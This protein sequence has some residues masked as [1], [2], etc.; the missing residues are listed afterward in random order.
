MSDGITFVRLTCHVSGWHL[1]SIHLA[2]RISCNQMAL[3]GLS[4]F[5]CATITVLTFGD[6]E[7]V[8]I[9][10]PGMYANQ[11]EKYTIV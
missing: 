3:S 7:D 2:P 4:T 11:N 1:R 10:I 8:G 5:E 9:L 6:A